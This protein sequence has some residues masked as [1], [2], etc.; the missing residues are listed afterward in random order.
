MTNYY[1]CGSCGCKTLF[2]INESLGDSAKLLA[3]CVQC[4]KTKDIYIRRRKVSKEQQYKLR[5]GIDVS[6]L[7][8]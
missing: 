4:F 8:P 5:R 6:Q 3:L 1:P 7:A 2:K